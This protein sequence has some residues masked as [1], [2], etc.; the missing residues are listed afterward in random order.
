[1]WVDAVST[2]CLEWHRTSLPSNSIG[3]SVFAQL[4]VVS[5]GHHMSMVH[6]SESIVSG[7]RHTIIS[8]GSVI[9]THHSIGLSSFR[10]FCAPF[11][12]LIQHALCTMVSDTV[13]LHDLN[14]GLT[15]SS[16][17]G[18]P[19]APSHGAWGSI[20]MGQYR[21]GCSVGH[22]NTP[23]G[24]DFFILLVRLDIDHL[25]TKFDTLASAIGLF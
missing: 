10:H 12:R 15:P 2:S 25:C 4:T 9:F 23:F 3:S 7:W 24:G 1:M 18:D 20:S 8:I 22:N 5:F 13:T 6:V 11:N 17:L 16:R 14:H 21:R 19:R